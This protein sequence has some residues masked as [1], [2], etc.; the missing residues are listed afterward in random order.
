MEKKLRRKKTDTVIAYVMLAP[1]LIVFFVFIGGP[2]LANLFYLS[3]TEYSFI[4]APE[5][6]GLYNFRDILQ[7]SR[8]RIVFS[9]TFRFTA[10]IIPVQIIVGLALALLVH[11]EKRGS[12][13][14]MH[15]TIIYFPGI[16]TGSAFAIAFAFLFGTEFGAVNYILR[17]LGIIEEAIPWTASSRW[18]LTI[19]L[20]YSV[21]RTIG[22]RFLF[23]LIGLQNIPMNYVEAARVD[24]ANSVQVFFRIKL[25]MLSP[26]MFFVAL[27]TTIGALQIFEEPF[28]ITGGGPLDS[29]RTVALFIYEI[30]FQ[31]FR[32]G[33]AASLATML[34]FIIFAVTVI[35]FATEKYWTNYDYE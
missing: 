8:T 24:G 6:V 18:S 16:V 9:N 28:L 20:I 25:P 7:D 29:S 23:F 5:F 27:T 22:P 21:W 19:I 13:S 14:A 31:R 1:A 33:Y 30:A 2:L 10:A 12:L 11:S 35:Y 26:M 3:M 15:R 34:F 4:R 32:M 17:S